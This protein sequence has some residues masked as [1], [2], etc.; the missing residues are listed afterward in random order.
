MALQ[1]LRKGKQRESVGDPT[2]CLD[3]ALARF[4]GILTAVEQ[5]Q[6]TDSSAAVPDAG[7]VLFFVAQLDA[8]NA[9]KSRRSIAP[10]LCTFLSA[11][12]QFSGAIGTFV[13]SNPAIAA[14]VWGGITTAITVASNV[15]SYFDKVTNMIKDIGL[16]CP[17]FHQFGQLYHGHV[18][19][20]NALCQ[21][22]AV[23][24]DTC[25][26][27]IEVSRRPA[28]I[29]TFC[30]I[31]NPFE[32][33]F[34]P[35]L[36]RLMAAKQH[37]DLQ[38]S[39]ASKQADQEAK[40]L[41]EHESKENS[42]FRPSALNLLKKS[43]HQQDEAR[44]WQINRAKREI[45][46]LKIKIQRDLC[47]V[48][49]MQPWKR[50]L[51]QRVHSTAEWLIHQPAFIEWRDSPRS[52]IMW[53]SG[54]MGMGKTVLM[55]NVVSHL[56]SFCRQT[57]SVAHFF[58][59]AENKE[60]L[61][62]R[63]IIG[64]IARQLLD[65]LIQT[66]S[67]DHLLSI[68][69]EVQSLDTDETVEF[70]LSKLKINH[71]YYIILDGLDECEQ[72][73]IRGIAKALEAIFQSKT[74]KL[75]IICAGRPDLDRDLFKAIRPEFRIVIDEEKL[76]IDMDRFIT[77]T[78]DECLQ[79][80]LLVIQD[81]NIVLTIA[82][83][84]RKGARGMFLWAGLCI[85]DLCEKNSDQEILD[86]LHHLPRD[87]A[88][89]FDS[90]IRRIQHERNS[91]QTMD[92][93]RYC[94]VVKRPLTI[95]ECR[96]ALSVS[97]EDKYL[98][99]RKLPNDMNR[100]V[101]G[102]FGLTFIDDEEYTI[103][104]IH[105]SV[106]DHLFNGENERNPRFDVE[107]I[108]KQLGALCMTYLNF[109]NFNRKL[110][111]VEK[112]VL[113]D[114]LSLATSSINPQVSR[115]NKI[116]L[117]LLSSRKDNPTTFEFQHVKQTA[118]EVLEDLES[119]RNTA[120]VMTNAA[121]LVYAQENWAFHLTG[122]QPDEVKIWSLF[123]KCIED[124]S[125]PLERHWENHD[126][127]TS[128]DTA[129]IVDILPF[130][131]RLSAALGYEQSELAWTLQH[132]HF[133]LFLYFN[134]HSKGP[135]HLQGISSFPVFKNGTSH[136]WLEALIHV[137]QSTHAWRMALVNVASDEGL[138]EA[139]LRGI[140]V[141][142]LEK[143][144]KVDSIA[145]SNALGFL[146]RY[147]FEFQSLFITLLSVDKVLNPEN[148]ITDKTY[149]SDF[150]YSHNGQINPWQI[151]PL[152]IIAVTQ[153]KQWMVD[154]I[155]DSGADPNVCAQES[156]NTAL[157]LA[158]WEN[159]GDFLK[160]LLRAGADVR[161]LDQDGKTAFDLAVSVDS[162]W[163]GAMKDF[164]AA[165]VNIDL[166][167]SLGK[168]A[169]HRA[170]EEGR[171]EMLN[172]LVSAGANIHLR[173]GDGKTAFHV[174]IEDDQLEK[175]RFLVSIGANVNTC[176]GD[177]RTPLGMA[178]E[179]GKLD[180]FRLLVSVGA[181][182]DLKDFF[183]ETALHMATKD[184]GKFD[185]VKDLVSAGADINMRD[186]LGYTALH[187]AV[188]SQKSG[189]DMLKYLVSAGADVN[190]AADDGHTALT[191][192][193]MRWRSAGFDLKTNLTAIE[194]IA[195]AVPAGQIYPRGFQSFISDCLP[196]LARFKAL[197]VVKLLVGSGADID[198]RGFHDS[199]TALHWA[200]ALNHCPMVSFLLESGVDP[201]KSD[202]RGQT[203]LHY[204]AEGGFE[205][206][207][208]CL[209]RVADASIIDFQGRTALM[210]ARNGPHYPIVKMLLPFAG[211]RDDCLDD[212]SKTLQYWANLVNIEGRIEEV[213]D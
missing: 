53:C 14:L 65:S 143:M 167:D 160:S 195:A 170:A 213:F 6:F 100:V 82:D 54:T 206:A 122:L 121:F 148:R 22:Y 184:D 79:E 204:A 191:L 165:G 108:N 124:R 13:S 8:E 154:A 87:L 156:S 132:N 182:V 119:R 102:C 44:Q 68:Q 109:S 168:T 189:L 95:E 45:A 29:Q 201:N 105:Q 99:T 194:Y 126:A 162:S 67:H 192:S 96:E 51:K 114:P 57:N 34:K 137:P 131:D 5:Q 42:L 181:D 28:S 86:A 104:Y 31:W 3:S 147:A 90:K 144:A 111:K 112:R 163:N 20:Q 175:V 179:N 209:L 138:R 177:G 113:I 159:S 71:S 210:C 180:M 40:N 11:T 98:D 164:V 26:R 166:K 190:L 48:D 75:K 61:S 211:P 107:S 101:R 106:K 63:N 58:C 187:E 92:L 91:Q 19:L 43:T 135:L 197:A 46:S 199:Q 37:I 128:F 41:L 60:S 52:T 49:H 103:H 69:S 203:A 141:A 2:K 118:L 93:L 196:Q 97:L 130:V 208:A 25:T 47:P 149:N 176:N 21:Y 202:N 142:L 123:C 151:N 33:E 23:I 89:L 183:G 78:L 36:D 80:E 129:Q 12:Q 56:H 117:K 125:L 18:G 32:S 30:L 1:L 24:V 212:H 173:N 207:V 171:L 133:A 85:K 146:L 193:L 188:K 178:V 127:V 136:R 139:E 70:L 72:A 198:S 116:A 88:D 174:A 64:S 76:S 16:F 94:G 152:L 83:A 66:S 62:A 39:L 74:L 172:S 84:L 186:F 161:L 140:F 59:M 38:V 55:S 15:A 185:F 27:I 120:G 4:K 50:T 169:L 7:G 157:H 200:S 150:H 145:A 17:T 134:D 205:E 110:T 155:L 115:V 35:F 158:V 10:R 9:S 153:G 81:P 73:Q 77:A